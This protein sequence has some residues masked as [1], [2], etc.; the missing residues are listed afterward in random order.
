[1]NNSDTYTPKEHFFTRL[2]YFRI[3]E[4]FKYNMYFTERETE[5]AQQSAAS[6]SLWQNICYS[7]PMTCGTVPV[8]WLGL[9]PVNTLIPLE[10]CSHSLASK[11][12]QFSLNSIKTWKLVIPILV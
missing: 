3:T 6:L 7:V 8:C 12:L 2:I 4:L 10:S 1:M 11:Y 5:A 9:M